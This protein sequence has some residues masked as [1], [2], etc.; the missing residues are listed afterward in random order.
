MKSLAKI[1]MGLIEPQGILPVSL[2]LEG[3]E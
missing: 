2:N 3:G 1:L